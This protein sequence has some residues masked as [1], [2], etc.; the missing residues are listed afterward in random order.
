MWASGSELS[1][2]ETWK[3]NGHGEFDT[4]N[5]DFSRKIFTTAEKIE[6]HDKTGKK[7]QGL[8]SI[9]FHKAPLIIF[10]AK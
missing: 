1:A 2:A 9:L 8:F 10:R 5:G 7:I 6:N 3:K 4:E